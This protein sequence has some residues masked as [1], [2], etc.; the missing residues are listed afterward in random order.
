M[1]FVELFCDQDSYSFIVE[2]KTRA[3]TTK[4]GNCF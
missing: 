4:E 3:M 1:N 2:A